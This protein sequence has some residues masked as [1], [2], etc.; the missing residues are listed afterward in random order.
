MVG[1]ILMALVLLVLRS[2]V[3]FMGCLW[4]IIWLVDTYVRYPSCFCR[5]MLH[6][7]SSAAHEEIV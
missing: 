1:R 7:A 3:L 5:C 4:L 2:H 6:F